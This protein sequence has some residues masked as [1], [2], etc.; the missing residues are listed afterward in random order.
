M[1]MNYL[2]SPCIYYGDEIGLGAQ[3]NTGLGSVHY[4]SARDWDESHWDH[5]RYNFYRALGELRTKYSAVKTGAIR[6]MLVS[7][8]QNLY[9]YGRWDKNGHGDH[10]GFAETL[11]P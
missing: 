6:E 2:G 9:A 8:E 1:Q 11:Q 7:D 10:R 3:E 4:M 5:A